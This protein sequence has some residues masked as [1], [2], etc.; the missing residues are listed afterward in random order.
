M[1]LEG[2]F[3]FKL[4]WDSMISLQAWSVLTAL[5]PTGAM[6]EDTH[7]PLLS[8]WQDVGSASHPIC[9]PTC[10]SLGT[11]CCH[12]P[13]AQSHLPVAMDGEAGIHLS[14]QRERAWM[15]MQMAQ[16]K[17]GGLGNQNL[18]FPNCII[19]PSLS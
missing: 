1:T 11:L 18:N 4:F 13:S 16:A 14:P 9:F 17:D 12:D 19:L 15:A 6:V 3:Q 8:S 7:R 5:K 10:R 2:P